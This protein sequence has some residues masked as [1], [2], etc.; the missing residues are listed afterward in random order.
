MQ[1][2]VPGQAVMSPIVPAPAAAEADGHQS[3]VHRR[4]V[5]L[6][7]PAKQHV[8][9]RGGA[10][11]VAGKSTGQVG[12]GARLLR[13]EVAEGQG[14]EGHGV[15]RLA[16]RNHVGV[17]P[18]L[19]AGRVGSGR[20]RA[21]WMQRLLVGGVQIGQERRP[22]GIAA[23]LGPLFEH[24]PL[25]L[26]EAELLHHELEPGP[27][28]VRPLA[29]AR[30]HAPHRLGDG[31]QLLFRKE[32]VEQLRRLRHG[33]EAPADHQLEPALRLA[34]FDARAGDGAHVVK[35]G[36]P[37]GV[38]L[39]ARERDL[40][41]A[42][43]VLR[44]VVA[45]QEERHRVRVRGDVEG[46]VA[47]DASVRAGGQV[48]DGVAAGFA[49]GDAGR[50]EP[51]VKV[52]R[53]VDVDVVE[54]DV[55]SGGD[56]Q[57]PVGILLGHLREDV[58]LIG[59]DLAVGD[60]DPLHA[61]G[62]PQRARPLGDVL[63]GEHERLGLLAIV[64]LAVVVPLAVGTAT[65]ARLGEQLLLD[66]PLLAQLDLRLEDVDLASPGFWDARAEAFLPGLA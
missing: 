53:V 46:L 63:G 8:L 65:E 19:E 2:S 36:E 3:L 7:D 35:V 41:L 30:E 45:E 6:A 62:V 5:G 26:F 60:L 16:L 37:A 18:G 51:P 22:A 27:R 21:G 59:R 57:N 29:E 47:A 50:G 12:E 23:Q 20:Q 38:V 56:V 28:P 44:V 49:G 55:L 58:E 10:H 1:V 52:R 54:L 39:A 61:G 66:L 25:R 13:G 32:G 48:A 17:T 42:S 9:I 40:E 31:Q 64:A 34:V 15:A 24:Q 4:E 11:G 43:E 14:H 33:P